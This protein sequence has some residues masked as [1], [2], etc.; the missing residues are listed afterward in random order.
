[1]LDNIWMD[2]CS[3]YKTYKAALTWSAA[4]SRSSKVTNCSLTAGRGIA[5][6]IENSSSVATY[7][8]LDLLRRPSIQKS[9]NMQHS[10]TLPTEVKDRDYS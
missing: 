1:M 2:G 5:V 6:L 3:Q 8:N 10:I 4:A 7:K 9:T